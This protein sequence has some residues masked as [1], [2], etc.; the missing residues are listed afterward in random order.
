MKQNILDGT[1]L[2]GTLLDE[3]AELSLIDLCCA[4]SRSAE[5]VIQLVEVG[6]LEPINYQE[7]HWRFAGYSLQRART[8]MRLQ[9]DLGVNFAGI[10][11]ALNL[12]EEIEKLESQLKRFEAGS[13]N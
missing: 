12:L 11:L 4:C 10:A 5:W 13:A 7:T 1:L 2:N 6:V 3:Q 8:A 9:R